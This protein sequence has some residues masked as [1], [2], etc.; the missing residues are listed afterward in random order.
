MRD[1]RRRVQSLVLVTV[2]LGS[3]CVLAVPAGA[4]TT[5]TPGLSAQSGNAPTDAQFTVTQG[6]SC[7]EVTPLGNGSQTVDSYFGYNGRQSDYSSPGTAELQKNQVSNLFVYHGSKGYSLGLVHDKY[8]NEPYGSTLT[9][10]FTGLPADGRWAVR[11]DHYNNNG[12]DDDWDI[13]G[14]TAHIDWKWAKYRTDG[15]AYRGLATTDDLQLH[16]DPEF[17]EAANHWQGSPKPWPVSGGN[18]RI[19]AWRLFTASGETVQLNMT[20][21]VTVSRGSCGSPGSPPSAALTV[22]PSNASVNATITLDASASSD[23]AG[24]R[25]YGWD[26]NGDGVVE[27]NTTMPTLTRTFQNAGDYPMAVTVTDTQGYTDTATTSVHVTAPADGTNGTN[28]TDGGTGSNQT[29]GSD[30]SNGTNTTDTSPPTANISIPEPVAVNQSVTIRAT[31]LSDAHEIVHVCWFVDGVAGPEGRVLEHTFDGTG[32][33]N[34][35]L[36]LKD[37]LGNTDYLTKNFTV[38]AN[39]SQNGG[40]DGSNGN[41]TGSNDGGSDGSNGG[42][43]GSNSGE[44]GSS[45]DSGGSDSGG[46]HSGGRDDSGSGGADHP[47]STPDQIHISGSIARYSGRLGNLFPNESAPPTV[48]SVQL[49]ATALTTGERVAATIGFANTT[50]LDHSFTV[51]LS[52]VDTTANGTNGTVVNRTQITVGTGQREATSRALSIDEPGQ[53]RAIIGN[54]SARFIV[55]NRTAVTNTTTPSNRSTDTSTQSDEESGITTPTPVPPTEAAPAEDAGST[56]TATTTAATT[57][58]AT[59]DTATTDADGPGFGL[60]G[61]LLAV[62]LSIAALTRRR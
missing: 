7:Y 53:Y 47:G 43:S 44:S 39:E 2:L 37:S 49:N 1:S 62:C 27:Q 34:V 17:N 23:D 12:Q 19:N 16:I 42:N 55:R 54:Q 45:G 46:S 57:D 40:S 28:G 6:G 9:M 50:G 13:G 59:T 26:L 52:V 32:T 33:H 5:G 41:K 15:G 14:T 25:T 51:N 4:T 58:T 11:D 8:G 3:S 10:N 56:T 36:M 38:A 60:I 20:Q 48:T 24:I 61:G 30:G 18:N 35:T 31:N 22:S 29:G 21:N